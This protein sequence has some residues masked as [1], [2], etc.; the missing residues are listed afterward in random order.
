[1]DPFLRSCLSYLLSITTQPVYLVGGSV[2]DLLI[3]KQDINDI[4]LLFPAGSVPAAR[5]FA[6]K[7]D[8]SFFFLDEERGI[9]RVVKQTDRGIVQFDFTNFD[10]PDLHADLGRRD[11]TVNAMAVSVQEFLTEQLSATVI[12]LFHGREDLANKLI[13]T[14]KPEVLDEDPLRLL[15]AVRFAATLGFG[16][17]EKTIRQIRERSNLIA[18]PSPE[19]VR[20]ELLLVLSERNA[21]KHLHMMESLGLL[22]PLLPELDPLRGFAPGRYQ[23]HDV[24]T[25]SIKT[26][27]YIDSVLDDLLKLSPEHAENVFAHLEEP[28]ER[29]APR[30]AVLRLACLLHDMAKPETFTD[31]DGRVRFH[32]HDS[33]GARKAGLLC[34]R[35]KLS[36]ES[37]SVVE[38]VI[39]DHMRL[40]NLATAAG[41]SNNA[42]YRYC[43]D[44]RNALPES[45][46]LAQADA[47]A[48]QEIMPGDKF[49]DTERIMATV[50]DY[51]YKK[52]LKAAARPLVNGQDLIQRGFEPGPR[53][54]EI[55]DEIR[56]LQ[57]DG[58]IKDRQGALEHLAR[59]K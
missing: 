5:A 54:R 19:R 13:R 50:L 22:S 49:T 48:T 15:R 28:L 3:G 10:G 51:Y 16:L 31:A 40:F 14:V 38:R 46:L 44:A 39:R 29:L 45:L 37:E 8:G 7:I 11:F 59:L 4:D 43:H 34:R 42:M 32:G 35:L 25:H 9:A 55:L 41:V 17:E 6:D 27:E 53:F 20:D 12:D 56:E 18:L 36:R 47:R 2:R 24:L 1:M 23:A 26:A 21:G 33:L 57:A 58:T 30:K 52:F